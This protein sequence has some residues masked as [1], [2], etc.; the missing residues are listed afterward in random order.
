MVTVAC[1]VSGCST[2]TPV[3]IPVV[4][5][6]YNL[7]V[8]T[9]KSVAWLPPA[10]LNVLEIFNVVLGLLPFASVR[11]GPTKPYAVPVSYTHLTLPTTPYV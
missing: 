8:D 11:Y 6:I 4:D 9:L 7:F 3:C 1:P 5:A 10:L 2:P